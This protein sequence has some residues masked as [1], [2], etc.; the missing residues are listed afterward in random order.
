VISL[1]VTS[2]ARLRSKTSEPFLR[3]IRSTW[4]RTRISIR[5]T[6]V[7]LVLSRVNVE[8]W[9]GSVISAAIR[10]VEPASRPFIEIFRAWHG[11]LAYEPARVRAP[12]AMMRGAWDGLISDADARWRF[13]AFS[14]SPM[15]RD[16]E[17]GRGT[18]L[19][20]LEAM[21]LAL[22]RES[23]TFLLGDDV[24]PVPI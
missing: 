10:G 19:M 24:A 14:H 13:D 12:V 23:V 7:A 9:G 2:P 6:S 3:G 5:G 18:D 16:V 4:R 15:K 22:W 21:R 1:R 11:E 20:R 17:I 8:D